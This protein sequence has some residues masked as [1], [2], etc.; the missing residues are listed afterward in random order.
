MRLNLAE[1]MS[2]PSSLFA[3][4]NKCQVGMESL[5]QECKREFDSEFGGTCPHCGIHV[6]ANLSRHIIDFHLELG[7]LWRC[8]VE[9][10]LVWKGTAQECMDHLPV[11]HQ[12][13][14]S[15]KIKTLD[16]YFPPGNGMR[17]CVLACPALPQTSCYSISTW[18]VGT[19]VSSLRRPLRG[20]LV[21]PFRLRRWLFVL[22]GRIPK[23]WDRRAPDSASQARK[24][25]HTTATVAFA[26]GVEVIVSTPGRSFPIEELA[27]HEL[28]QPGRGFSLLL[29]QYDMSNT[30]PAAFLVVPPTYVLFPMEGE[31]LFAPIGPSGSLADTL[32]QDLSLPGSPVSL[33]SSGPLLPIRVQL[34]LDESAA[35]RF[36]LLPYLPSVHLRSCRP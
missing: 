29:P 31:V 25:K 16:Q 32:P 12:T 30:E 14:T 24:A 18:P 36:L 35:P 6:M 1:T 2:S 3:D 22:P 11:R 21:S 27:S 17:C 28:L 19:P 10:C 5:C 15:V 34:V 20:H 4:M 33:L 9:W 23:W 26:A 13:D 8:P 7:Q